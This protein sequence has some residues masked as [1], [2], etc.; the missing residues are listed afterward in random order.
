MRGQPTLCSMGGHSAHLRRSAEQRNKDQAPSF[1]IA[2]LL[3]GLDASE[4][5]TLEDDVLT[6]YEVALRLLERDDSLSAKCLNQS[7]SHL[8][9]FRA[10]TDGT[11]PPLLGRADGASTLGASLWVKANKEVA[12]NQGLFADAKGSL[13]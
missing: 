3:N 8:G 9:W 13:P 12:R 5:T 2:C 7:V 1:V 10:K 6:G 11:T 4:S